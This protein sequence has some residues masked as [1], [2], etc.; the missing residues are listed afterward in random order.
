MR[1]IRPQPAIASGLHSS[2]RPP[3]QFSVRYASRSFIALKLAL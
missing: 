1:T 3:Q 2:G